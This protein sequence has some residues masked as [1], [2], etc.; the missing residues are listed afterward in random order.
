MRKLNGIV[1]FKLDTTKLPSGIKVIEYMSDDKTVG[2]ILSNGL[3]IW[4]AT[5]DPKVRNKLNLTRM[6]KNGVQK[7]SL[8]MALT[9]CG[10]PYTM[11][12]LIPLD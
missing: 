8:E 6:V 12:E 1:R 3:G 2:A 5:P 11:E 7:E 9:N 4:K 10:V